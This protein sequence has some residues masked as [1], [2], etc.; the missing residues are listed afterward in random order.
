ML[1]VSFQPYNGTI[2]PVYCL[3]LVVWQNILSSWSNVPESTTNSLQ[4]TKFAWTANSVLFLGDSVMEVNQASLHLKQSLVVI[5]T[6]LLTTLFSLLLY[7]ISPSWLTSLSV[8]LQPL[9]PPLT[10]FKAGRKGQDFSSQLFILG[11]K[12]LPRKSLHPSVFPLCL[13]EWNWI[14]CPLL[15][16]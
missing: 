3:M 4:K 2:M 12:I 5:W 6:V 7:Q 8:Q 1:C 13:T 14:T 16:H 10:W 15:N 9:H 11:S